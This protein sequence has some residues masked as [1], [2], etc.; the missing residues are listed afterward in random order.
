MSGTSRWKNAER[1][2]AAALG[3]QRLPN[4]GRGQPDVVA[5]P[6][7]CQVK[8][9]KALPAW[10][11]AAV[12]QAARDAGADGVPV[13]VLNEVRRGVKARRLVVLDLDDFRRLTVADIPP[14]VRA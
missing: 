2:I 8:T 11:V 5:G 3:G 10:L 13:V 12:E 6:F 1:Q 9:T 7:R 4:N 14:E